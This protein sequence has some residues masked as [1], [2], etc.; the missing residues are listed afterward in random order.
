LTSY[1]V[2][3]DGTLPEFF[4]DGYNFTYDSGGHVLG[5]TI[6][7]IHEFDH[8]GSTA[9][10]DFT[11]LFNAASWM[12]AVQ[13]IGANGYS[14][15][16]T[17][18]A[19]YTFNFVGGSGDDSFGGAGSSATYTG[20]A[21]SD[22]FG[23][24]PG[25]GAVTITDF[26]QGNSGVN[27]TF[28]QGEGDQID[29]SQ[30][31]SVHSLSDVLSLATTVDNNGAANP[32]G[33]NTL[34]DFG[35][36]D[37]LTI[38]GLT[39]DQLTAG[40]FQFAGGAAP[41]EPF[42]WIAGS[43]D[44]AVG[45]NWDSSI[46]PGSLDDAAIHPTDAATITSSVDE[47]VSTLG[48][49]SNATL[50]V[51]GGTFTI[52][53]GTG[54]DS[55]S[56]VIEA[57]GG[58][59]VVTE[60]SIDNNGGVIAAFAGS[61]VT[62][63]GGTIDNTN[64]GTANAGLI[65]AIG[66]TAV[67]NIENGATIIG[68]TIID[69]GTINI[70]GTAT[71]GTSAFGGTNG[72]VAISDGTASS[73]TGVI[74]NTGTLTLA[75][76]FKLAGTNFTLDL[77]GS[78]TLALNGNTIVMNTVTGDIL[79]NDGNTISGTGQIGTGNGG[80][81]PLI[82]NNNSGTIEALG[83]T[84][85]ISNG[86]SFT[87]SGLLEAAA[88][89]TLKFTIGGISN[90]GITPL[91]SSNAA[92]VLVDG[93]L[94]IANPIPSGGTTGKFQLGGYGSTVINGGTIEGN[95]S[96]AE[97]FENVNN[98][99]SGYGNIGVTGDQ[100]TLQND[101]SG[102][103]DA[104]VSGQT[105]NIGTG[106]NGIANAG[107]MEAT[108]GGILSINSTVTNSGAGS[109]A[110]NG[111]TVKVGSTGAINGTFNVLGGGV[112]E[113]VN[114]VSQNVA[115]GGAGTLL[116]DDSQAYTNGI[117]SGFGLGDAIDL[118]DLAYGSNETLTWSQ[119]TGTLTI[120]GGTFTDTVHLAGTYTQGDFALTNSSGN[121]EVVFA[122]SL[123]GELKY[124]S[125][126]QG[127]H[128]FGVNPQYNSTA[129][130]LGFSYADT[131]DYS[132]SETS[133][134]VTQ[135]IGSLD[136]FFLPGRHALQTLPAFT[137]QAPTRTNLILPNLGSALQPEG[138]QVYKG[139]DSNGGDAIWQVLITPDSN[140]DGGLTAGAATQI[141]NSSTTGQAIYNLS[142]GYKTSGTSTS[143][144][145][146]YDVAWD[147][148]TSNGH[149]SLEIQLT[150]IDPSSGNFGTPIFITP[151]ITETGGFTSVTPGSTALLP[152]WQFRSAG[153]GATS[154]IPNLAYVLAI[155]ETDTTGGTTHQA[156]HFQGYTAGGS[157]TNLGPSGEQ[158]VL[159]S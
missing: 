13:Q 21:G 125:I 79:D 28:D 59:H 102:V 95:S 14:A 32:N 115:F 50:D 100:L 24:G 101:A 124:P 38:D 155:A 84:L 126:V 47:T 122:P 137:V 149:Y 67:V 157:S 135:N 87:N 153:A 26:D 70:T 25:S 110:A 127:D 64:G 22:T 139:E 145:T 75:N 134:T 104:N 120:N 4:F 30:V 91:A 82:I 86:A 90:Q 43:G 17:L 108:S 12:A 114:S 55:S 94:E 97:L 72:A 81:D 121:A 119:N 23:F 7:A 118:K 58:G 85:Q 63:D 129:G 9:I 44:F 46:V 15:I 35:N 150:T 16:N 133:Y 2:V 60:G 18:V 39:P 51:T 10:A 152:G 33:A 6:T 80:A 65:K 29:L 131:S 105:L 20:G 103:I 132:P 141:G 112:A 34:I 136:P 45:S 89:A 61:V 111:G 8:T 158:R 1:T 19:P 68:G 49:N 37:T 128:G 113:I 5:G 154:T 109:V 57:T 147:Q 74:Y 116:L 41:S 53:N 117:V 31:T 36:G 99:V 76:N 144:A 93:T 156:I 92:G 73:G 62:I 138:I 130:I 148:Y 48:L 66:S 40:D 42:N 3:N 11:G 56:G 143:A 142:E 123:W 27:H 71:F 77:Q 106:A 151:V 54:S 88:G 78:G 69:T 52:L 140:G 98:A 146:S 83:G 96:N 107:T 159:V